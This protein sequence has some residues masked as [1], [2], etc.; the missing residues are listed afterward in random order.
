VL[1]AKG[2]LIQHLADGSCR[3]LEA[4]RAPLVVVHHLEQDGLAAADAHTLQVRVPEVFYVECGAVLRRWDLNRVACPGAE[5]AQERPGLLPCPGLGTL[6]PLN[7]REQGATRPQ[8]GT[9][10]RAEPR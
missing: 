8:S 1:D 4:P 6:S 3:I 9:S 7:P 10:G 2:D 5:A